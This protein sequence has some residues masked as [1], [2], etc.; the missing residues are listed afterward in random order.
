MPTRLARIAV[1]AGLVAVLWLLGATRESDHRA[2][3]RPVAAPPGPVRILRF[4][5]SVGTLTAGDKA[6]L[7]Y[8]VE[9]AKA[10]RISPSV[11]GAIPS[12]SHCLEI[13]PE[14]T[15]HYI[16][17]AEGYDGNVATRSLILPV[18]TAPSLPAEGLNIAVW[19]PAVR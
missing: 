2:W 18:R 8:G 9:N 19:L 17:L 3:V 13:V 10:V 16:I 4:Y 7:C 5:T 15:T 12:L 14:H 6:Q 11:A 1:A